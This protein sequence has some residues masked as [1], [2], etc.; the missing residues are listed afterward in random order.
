MKTGLWTKSAF[1]KLL[2]LVQLEY[3]GKEYGEE[4]RRKKTWQKIEAPTM[5][6]RSTLK[7]TEKC[8]E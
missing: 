8:P 3:H 6:V 7:Q 4:S 5:A 2:Q 1:E